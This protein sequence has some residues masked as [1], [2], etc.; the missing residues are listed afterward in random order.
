[1]N[2]VLRP[3]VISCQ[4]NNNKSNLHQQKK[5]IKLKRDIKLKLRDKKLQVS[6][7]CDEV[8]Y[9]DCDYYCLNLLHSINAL[10]QKEQQIDLLLKQLEN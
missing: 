1:M 2:K 6:E 7:Y 5:L 9:N 4:S 3:F 10:E 8:F